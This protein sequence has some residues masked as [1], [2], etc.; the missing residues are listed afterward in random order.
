[1]EAEGQA[2]TRRES[3]APIVGALLASVALLAIACAAMVEVLR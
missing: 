3:P 1:M 2:M